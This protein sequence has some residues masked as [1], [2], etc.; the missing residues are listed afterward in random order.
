VGTVLL[1]HAAQE[2]GEADIAKMLAAGRA[3]RRCG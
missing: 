2:V 3:A 1:E